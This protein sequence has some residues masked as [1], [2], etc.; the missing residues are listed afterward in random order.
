[1]CSAKTEDEW[2]QLA[3]LLHLAKGLVINHLS[4]VPLTT[5]THKAQ[6][7]ALLEEQQTSSTLKP[8]WF[9]CYLLFYGKSS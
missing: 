6:G 4:F 9:I 1:M 5:L 8:V 7:Y 2:K 3:S